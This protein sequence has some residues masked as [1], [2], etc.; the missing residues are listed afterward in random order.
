MLRESRTG[1]VRSLLWVDP[2]GTVAQVSE[3]FRS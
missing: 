2:D 3:V 1:R